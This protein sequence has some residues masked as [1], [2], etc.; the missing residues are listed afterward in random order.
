MPFAVWVPSEDQNSQRLKYYKAILYMFRAHPLEYIAYYYCV[1]D[2]SWFTWDAKRSRN[3]WIAKGK[4]KHQ[5]PDLSLRIKRL[6]LWSV[7]PVNHRGTQF[8][9]YPTIGND[10]LPNFGS[11]SVSISVRFRFSNIYYCILE[12]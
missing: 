11:V 9:F 8:L 4:R 3:N 7:S 1:E 5:L 6:W 10:H 12:L 2:K